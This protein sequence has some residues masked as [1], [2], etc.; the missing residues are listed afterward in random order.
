MVYAL[1]RYNKNVSIDIANIA[2]ILAYTL[3]TGQN[4]ARRL[5]NVNGKQLVNTKTTVC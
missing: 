3:N 1:T 2:H 5:N 4:V